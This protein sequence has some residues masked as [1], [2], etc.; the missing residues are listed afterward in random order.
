MTS[1]S[2]GSTYE[3]DYIVL[4]F[5]CVAYLTLWPPVPPTL[6]Q[7]TRFHP[8]Y[9]WVAVHCEYVPYFL[10]HSSV[11]G[12]LGCLHVLT[13]VNSAPIKIGVQMSLGATS[14][15]LDIFPLM[16]LMGHMVV[17]LLVFLRTLYTVFH[18]V[19]A[20]Y[21]PTVCKGSI[22]ST[23]VEFFYGYPANTCKSQSCTYFYIS[24]NHQ[25]ALLS[26]ANNPQISLSSSSSVLTS[27]WAP[28]CTCS[29]SELFLKPVPPLLES[30]MP[31]L[32][33]PS[34]T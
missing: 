21:I 7:M 12:H 26:Q 2:V 22:F 27:S 29:T 34:F 28:N 14:F 5:L 9:G 17:L 33:A 24:Y 8:L 32:Y 13:I 20:I 1:V 25:Y 4:L 18:N 10:I 19:F 15:P 31:F 3:S 6:S 23:L 16:E 30:A 11:S